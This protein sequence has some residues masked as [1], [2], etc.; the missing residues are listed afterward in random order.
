MRNPVQEV[1]HEMD[2]AFLP[3]GPYPFFSEGILDSQM[4]IR[5][6]ETDFP[7]TSSRNPEDSVSV[8][9]P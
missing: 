8:F 7:H 2:L 6:T 3:D 1:P 9:Q 4:G 5:N